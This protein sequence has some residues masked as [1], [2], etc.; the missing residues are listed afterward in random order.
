MLQ[1]ISGIFRPPILAAV[2]TIAVIG[3][4]GSYLVA[5]S[6][7][8][9]PTPKQSAAVSKSQSAAG[10]QST[11][12]K[13]YSL[14]FAPYQYVAYSGSLDTTRRDSG[15]KQHFAAF[16]ISSNGCTPTWGGSDANGVTSLRSSQ[17]S[18]DINALREAGG[19]AAVSFGGSNGI[20]L[21]SACDSKDTLREAYQTV[22]RT[23]DLKRVDFDIE[24]PSLADTAAGNR[25]AQAIADLQ[26]L[27]PELKVWVTL[28]VHTA[29]LPA[30]GVTVLNQM[31]D[32]GVVV[33]GVNIMAMNYNIGDIDMGQQAITAAR[34]SFTQMQS[35]YRDASAATI[36]KGMGITAMAGLN[37]TVPEKFTLADAAHL[38]QFAVQ[39]GVGMLSLW[40]T[41]RDMSCPAGTPTDQ[42]STSCSGVVQH[43][44]DFAKALTIPALR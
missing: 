37:N 27:K 31:R 19:D 29:G 8:Q 38:R 13:P 25:R 14:G 17:I 40:N 32:A 28:P 12:L 2:L 30:P 21:A 3:G 15:V 9:T 11:G 44:Y 23:Y 43:P 24:G 7:A 26:R 6:H 16:V 10:G 4:L 20:E 33:S 5:S 39:Q 42:A 35:V 41:G 1:K 18:S 34:A 22:I 36:W